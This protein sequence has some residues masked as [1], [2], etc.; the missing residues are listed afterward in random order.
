MRTAFFVLTIVTLISCSVKPE[1]L[2]YGKDGCH[3]CK[4]TLVD[5]KFGAEIITHK[6]KIY[7]FDDVNCLIGFYESG[8]VPVDDIMSVLVVEFQEPN[9]FVDATTAAY[10]ISDDVRSPMG[11]GVAAFGSLEKASSPEVPFRGEI[12]DWTQLVARF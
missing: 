3:S 11:S 12:V 9:G 10:I 2:A 8:S 4:M 5:H 6:G 7:K 1:P